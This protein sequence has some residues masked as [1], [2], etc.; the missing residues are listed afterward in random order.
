MFWRVHFQC[1]FAS[2]I[3][4]LICDVL[5]PLV[6]SFNIVTS[7]ERGQYGKYDIVHYLMSFCIRCNWTV[8]LI[9]AMVQDRSC[10]WILSLASRGGR[11]FKATYL[12]TPQYGWALRFT[13]NDGCRSESEIPYRHVKTC[14]KWKPARIGR[15][16]TVSSLHRWNFWLAEF[17]N[18][19]SEDDQKY[20]TLLK[21]AWT[22]VAQ[23][24]A[25]GSYGNF[26]T[27]RTRS[28]KLTG[29]IASLAPSIATLGPARKCTT[30]NRG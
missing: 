12:I 10:Q 26:I 28:G 21:K 16:R 5:F 17:Q 15:M 25:S 30:V 27:S 2:P 4:H 19:T 6:P 11:I 24:L 8:A 3:L 29:A 22:H 7:N 9:N 13:I 23:A 20:S 14:R 1:H 18:W